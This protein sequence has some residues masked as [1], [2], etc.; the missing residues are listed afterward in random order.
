MPQQLFHP[1]VW[2]W[3]EQRFGKPTEA[4]TQGWPHIAAG[5]HTLIAAPTGSG[6]TLA[7]FMV[8]LDRLFRRAIAGTLTDGV[9]TVYVSPLKALSND[10]ERNL[11]LPL[12]ELRALFQAHGLASSPVQVAVRTGDTPASERQAML[13]RPPHLLVTTPES[14]YLLLT[15]ERGRTILRTTQTVIVDE[16]HALAR[17]KRGSHLSLTLERL[18]WLCQRRLVRIGLS[19]TQ[20]PMEQMAR[21]LIGCGGNEPDLGRD[22]KTCPP[23]IQQQPRTVQRS[24]WDTAWTAAATAAVP[25][26]LDAAETGGPI[27]HA[28]QETACQIV[29]VGH[30][31][32]LDV[33]VEVPDSELAA[34]CS[35]EQWEEIY[36]RLVELINSHRST[37]VFVNTRRM[38]E[39]VAQRL[40]ERLGETAV[41]G[42]HG[43]MSRAIRHAAEQRLKAGE[44]KAIVATASLEMGI[45]IGYLDLVCQIGSPRSIANCLQRIGRSGHALQA[46]PKGRLFPLTRD[47]LL[48]CMALVRAIRRHSLDTIEIPEAPLDILAQQIVA[49]VACEEWD[50][51]GLLAL[52]RRAWPYRDLTPEVF[53]QIVSMVSDGLVPGNRSGAYLH[54]DRIHRRLRARKGARIAAITSGGAIPENAEYRVVTAEDRTFVGTVDEDFAIES[55][56]GDIFLL[57]N[58]SW[59]IAFVRG[60]EVV[61]TDAHGAPPSIPFWLGEAPGRT[62]EL[63]REISQLR[64]D[65]AERCRTVSADC[66]PAIHGPTDSRSHDI[67]VPQLAD[68]ATWLQHECGVNAMAADQSVRYVAAQ[69]AAIG[70]VPT[71]GQIVFERFFDESGGM[72][73]V[74]HSLFGTRIN[75][76]WGLAFRKRFCRSFDFELQAAATDNGILLSLGPQHSVPIENLFKMLGPHNGQYLLEQAVLAVPMFQVRWRWNVTRALAVL[77]QRNGKKVP[78]YLQRFR[79]EDLLAATFPETVGC[80]ENHHGDVQVPDHPLVR[81][82][83]HDCLQEAMDV[84]RWL[85]VLQGIQDGHITLV[86]R[87]TREPSPF[88]HELLNANPYAFL[89]DAPLEERRTR[90]V[91]TRRSLTPGDF[92]E[93]GQLDPAAIAQVQAEAWPEVRNADELHD[94]LHSLTMLRADAVPEWQDWFQQL[95]DR[96]RATRFWH[97]TETEAYWVVAERLPLVRAVFPQANW[98]PP[99]ELPADLDVVWQSTD[100]VVELVRGRMIHAGP[101]TAARIATELGLAESYVASALEAIEGQG[102]VLRGQFWAQTA[103]TQWCERRLLARIHRLTL[104][105]LRRRI[106]PV[107]P[108]DYLRFLARHHHLDQDPWSGVNGVREAIAQLQ[109]FEMPA[110]VWEPTI[111]ARVQHYDPAWLDQL[112]MTG[113][114]V[115]GR[116]RGSRRADET[117]PN[118]TALTRAM[119]ISLLLRRDLP[120]LLRH[121]ELPSE[122]SPPS[123]R[124]RGQS[125][126]R[127]GTKPAATAFAGG[128]MRGNAHQVYDVLVAHG[129]LFFQDLVAG[130]D[131]PSAQVEEGLREL[132]ALG[133]VT[134]DGFSAVRSII[135]SP[136]RGRRRLASRRGAVAA[137]VG[138]WSLFPGL[139]APQAAE[140]RLQQWC[141]Q[142]LRRY[143]IV[144]RDLLARE[145]AAPAWH[146]LVPVF[147]RLELR[148][149]VR[150]GRFVRSV[151]GEQF[152]LHTAV[153]HL[154]SPQP[155]QPDAWRLI[156]ASDPLNLHGVVTDEN[157]VPAMHKNWLVVRDGRCLAAQQAGSIAWFAQPELLAEAEMRRALQMGYRMRA[158]AS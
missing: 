108:P 19:A 78:P 101:T 74:I 126:T 116:L 125:P 92:R 102:H 158:V 27:A 120:W 145:N 146:E 84:R 140:T 61:V 100:A 26:P 51:E 66:D 142:L 86:A 129:A 87:D 96:G 131:L 112:F 37:L 58:T 39:R 4:Q 30:I 103:D 49:S 73:L 36:E 123:A 46:I 98:E 144:F 65:I 147:R 54:R 31:R 71:H 81:Q 133:L 153:D 80:L 136:H 62:I 117:R 28:S 113:E 85:E 83:M 156:S 33:R 89:D 148:G 16:I 91:T 70:L 53:D 67:A 155:Q 50:E 5:R 138:R 44:L 56:A 1:L 21:F 122:P 63:S 64:H 13:R 20:R 90:A 60:G 114:V 11:Q 143:G 45:D 105:G 77:R 47:E 99:V 12:D 109:G 14:L 3:F 134:S 29:D 111:A 76:A 130:A 32:E 52:A 17:D 127:R 79:S 104:D 15:S 118:L 2:Q 69:V 106:Q 34:V 110:A 68:P 8:C 7:A 152:A 124:T 135:H 97:T 38:A 149:D 22:A 139:V 18:N 154:R 115:W 40:R 59:R 25:L 141:F 137:P 121:Q 35:Q 42:H 128:G 72:Q 9:Q 94:A 43:S 151:G 119:P 95:V 23:P 93:L 48:E 41:A 132:A 24:L 57:G 10:I 88:S 157:R 150:G 6:K 75:R 107:E 82:T 55:S